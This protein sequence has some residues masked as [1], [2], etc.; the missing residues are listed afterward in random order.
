MSVCPSCGAKLHIY[1]VSQFCP[2]CKVNMR[3]YGFEDRFY[4]EAKLAELSLARVR[5]KVRRFKASLIGSKLAVARLCVMLLPAISLLIPSADVTLSLP[6]LRQALPMNIMSLINLFSG[7]GFSFIN[8]MTA[9]TV[10]GSGFSALLLL[11]Y[12]QAA[13]TLFAVLAFL[14]SL[15]SFISMRNM[16]KF[17]CTACAVG[18]A[19]CIADYVLALKF[20]AAV[21]ASSSKMLSG[22]IGIGMLVT[23]AAFAAV[24]AVNLLL[25]KKPIPVIYEEGDLERTEISA[26]I[27]SG[28]I[29]LCDLPQ[30]IVETAETRKINEEIKKEEEAFNKKQAEALDEREA[31]TQ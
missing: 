11:I 21:S 14:L 16:P 30:P 7:G 23:V 4:H 2:E 3:F 12:S 29:K 19:A 20:A 27:K 6:F 18:G 15:L 26:K 31:L 17:A 5:V 22:N 28:E 9:S 8:D 1:N 25:I 24:F 10:N 13:V